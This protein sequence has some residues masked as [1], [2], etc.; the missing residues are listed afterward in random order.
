MDNWIKNR[1]ERSKTFVNRSRYSGTREL[2]IR[3]R[4][5]KKITLEN[6]TQ[7]LEFIS[8]SYLGLDQHP[9]V[10]D[11][12][13]ESAQKWGTQLACARTRMQTRESADLEDLLAEMFLKNPCVTFNSVTMTHLGIFPLFVSGSLPSFEI[14]KDKAI[15]FM[16]KNSHSSIKMN[17]HIVQQFG[18]LEFI[19]VND[20]TEL[21]NNFKQA[22]ASRMTPILISDGLGSMGGGLL[23]ESVVE[24]CE[25]YDGYAYIDDAHG[26]STLG[27]NGTGSIFGHFQKHRSKRLLLT[28][29]LSKAFGAGGGFVCLPSEMDKKVVRQNSSTYLFSGPLQNPV[30]GAGI[31]SPKIHLSNEI[32][33]LQ[34]KL[35]SNLRLFDRTFEGQCIN[36]NSLSPIRGILFQDDILANKV[37]EG[38]IRSGF[39]GTLAQYPSVPMGQ[40]RI[41]LAISSS[42]S[43]EDILRIAKILNALLLD[44]NKTSERTL[45]NV[46]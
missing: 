3:E 22:A 5:N 19:D 32:N 7:L 25:Q 1:I 35:Q 18:Q 17:R 16:D 20:L 30:V 45:N 9:K 13:I 46:L 33:Q 8:C 4:E 28:G 14:K 36:K 21:K 27:T 24:F 6:G 44:R 37:S 41:R 40:S 15:F 10:I 29:S 2:I 12:A 39:V 34:S 43:Q 38:L 26:I 11:G 23:S 31:A 42:H